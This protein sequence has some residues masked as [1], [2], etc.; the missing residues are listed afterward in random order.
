MAFDISEDQVAAT[1]AILGRKLPPIYRALMMRNNGG[2]A[3]DEEDQWELHPIRDNSDRKR[4]SR[5]CNHVILETR[6][7]KDWNGFPEQALAIGGNGFGD[8]MILLPSNKDSSTYS[9]EIFVFMHETAE[10]L[11]KADNLSS[12]EFE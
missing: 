4:L 3:F 6:A 12:Y 8:I 10:V 1:E 7:A 9:D 5:T 11:A 2:T